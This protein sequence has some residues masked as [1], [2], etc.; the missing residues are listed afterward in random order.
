MP[1]GSIN[2]LY[3]SHWDA[4]AAKLKGH[5]ANQEIDGQSLDLAT[6]IAT[7]RYI[8][9]AHSLATDILTRL[10]YGIPSHLSE[11]SIAAVVKTAEM[12]QASIDKGEVV[13]GETHFPT[14]YHF[15][16]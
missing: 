14:V 5:S 10:R 15:P 12:L 2:D 4:I 9:L 7:A 8:S 11:G 3:L 16:S 1:L 13:Y 6:V